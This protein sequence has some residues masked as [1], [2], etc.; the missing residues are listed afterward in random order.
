VTTVP[1][2]EDLIAWDDP[3]DTTPSLIG[4]ECDHCGAFTFPLGNS[5]PRCGIQSPRRV[6]L[7]RQGTIWSWTTQGFAPKAPFS[8]TA[9]LQEP[10]QPWLVG[11]V[12][13]PGQLRLESIIT[14]TTADQIHIGM[15][16]RLTTIPFRTDEQGR[17]VISFAFEPE[18]GSRG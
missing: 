16:V 7:N 15:A 13:L 17:H 18:E 9:L 8:G 11:L 2:A 12:E 3:G 1:I 10:F 14:G 5:C 6:L 4:G